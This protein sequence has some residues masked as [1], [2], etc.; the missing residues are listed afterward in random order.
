MTVRFVGCPIVDP[1]ATEARRMGSGGSDG[2]PVVTVPIPANEAAFDV[3][4]ADKTKCV[5]VND[6]AAEFVYANGAGDVFGIPLGSKTK[7]FTGNLGGIRKATMSGPGY[8]PGRWLVIF[9]TTTVVEL[10]AW[11]V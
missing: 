4:I 9:N 8:V 10:V 11:G 5:N 2:N 3:M 6:L 1:F 7:V